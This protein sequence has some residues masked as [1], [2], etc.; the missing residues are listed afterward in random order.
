MERHEL[1]EEQDREAALFLL[2]FWRRGRHDRRNVWLGPG[3]DADGTTPL[4]RAAR[5]LSKDGFVHLR[6]VGP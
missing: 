5:R 6:V 4:R 3:M 2:R 1:V